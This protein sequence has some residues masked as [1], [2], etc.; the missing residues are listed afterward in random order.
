MTS[1]PAR[2]R[3][4]LLAGCAAA[5]ALGGA[6]LERADPFPRMRFA[7]QRGSKELASSRAVDMRDVVRGRPLLSMYLP[8]AD[9]ND[10]LAHKMEH[11]R[12]WERAADI[13]YYDKGVL[14]FAGQ[15]GVRIHGG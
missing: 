14:R 2:S 5:L 9:L 12:A 3:L 1:G 11:G 10:L 4:W 8:P 6:V 15:V 7:I 13:S